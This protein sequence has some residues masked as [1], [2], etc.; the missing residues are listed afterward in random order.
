[1]NEK[2]KKLKTIFSAAD[3]QITVDEKHKLETLNLL[4][5]KAKTLENHPMQNKKLLLFNLVRYIDRNPSIIH[6][7]GCIAV[8]LMLLAM[9]VW[10]INTKT[11]IFVSMILPCLLALLSAFEIRQVCFVKIAELSETCF[12]HVKQL[13]ALSIALSGIMNLMAISAGILLVGFR[14][15]IKLLHIGLYVLVPFLFMQCI[16]FG[17]MLT[18]AGRKY[19]WLNAVLS[20]PL[21]LFCVIIVQTQ[22]LYTNSALLFWLIALLTGIALLA[23]ETKIFFSKLEKGDILCTNLS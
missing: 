20:I 6:L 18:E 22:M 3:M 15:K 4:Y 12:F 21:A 5:Q 7:A 8:F 17:T 2:T 16:C 11:T 9:S 19:I 23:T 1:M 13:A 10:N 14:W